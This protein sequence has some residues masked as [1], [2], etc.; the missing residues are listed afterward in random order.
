MINSPHHAGSGAPCRMYCSCATVSIVP[1][2]AA[3]EQRV[4][5]E[6]DKARERAPAGAL[7]A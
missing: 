7:N 5:A 6:A 2:R 3:L 1:G 4:L